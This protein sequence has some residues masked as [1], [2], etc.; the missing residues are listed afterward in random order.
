MKLEDLHICNIKGQRSQQGFSDHCINQ[1]GHGNWHE[2]DECGGI[3]FCDLHASGKRVKVKCR[4]IN[5]R[6]LADL[7]KR[8][9]L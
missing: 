6:E 8:G 9:G 4:P 3:E 1:C 2:K 7:K 5:K